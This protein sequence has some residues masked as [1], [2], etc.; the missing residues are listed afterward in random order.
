MD[1]FISIEQA[2]R[3]TTTF[4]ENKE[5]ILLP[6]Y[7]GLDILPNAETFDRAAFDSVLAQTGCEKLRIYYGMDTELK[8]HAIIVGVNA[9]NTDMLPGTALTAEDGFVL[10]SESGDTLMG[11]PEGVIIET[12]QRCPPDCTTSPLNP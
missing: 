12:G 2:I 10:A 8:V 3:M 11:E 4:R 9:E 5:S 7:K 6:Q 1:H